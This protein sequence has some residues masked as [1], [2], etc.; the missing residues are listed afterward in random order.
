VL[1]GMTGFVRQSGRVNGREYS[2]INARTFG[3]NA[4][5]MFLL[6]NKNIWMVSILLVSILENELWVILNKWLKI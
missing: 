6:L 1:S 4:Y 5:A 3:G 2:F